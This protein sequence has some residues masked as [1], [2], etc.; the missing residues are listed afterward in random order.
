[1]C[2]FVMVYHY[3]M[4]SSVMFR[5]VKYRFLTYHSV[6]YLLCP[7]HSCTP[8]VSKLC[9]CTQKSPVCFMLHAMFRAAAKTVYNSISV[10]NS[11]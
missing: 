9:V 3:M 4:Y 7:H 10:H 8:L 11:S 6:M 2:R 5:S 1:M